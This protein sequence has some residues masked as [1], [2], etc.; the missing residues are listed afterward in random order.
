MEGL[1][2]LL[3]DPTADE[4]GVPARTF[5]PIFEALAKWG[6]VREL[7]PHLREFP[8]KDLIIFKISMWLVDQGRWGEGLELLWGPL[9]RGD[10]RHDYVTHAAAFY[11]AYVD[12]GDLADIAENDALPSVV[13]YEAMIRLS[14]SG[15]PIE[16]LA[17]SGDKDF[18]QYQ[19]YMKETRVTWEDAEFGLIRLRPAPIHIRVLRWLQ[20][21][22]G[23]V[24]N[25]LCRARRFVTNLRYARLYRLIEDAEEPTRYPRKQARAFVMHPDIDPR[26]RL[27]VSLKMLDGGDTDSAIECILGLVSDLKRET[28][29]DDKSWFDRRYWLTVAAALL[30]IIDR[31]SEVYSL[32]SLGSLDEEV[33]FDRLASMSGPVAIQ[34]CTGLAGGRDSDEEKIPVHVKRRSL[35]MLGTMK[36]SAELV[37]LVLSEECPQWIK[38]HAVRELANAGAAT[39]LLTIVSLDSQDVWTRYEAVDALGRLKRAGD[40]IALCENPAAPVA[41]RRHAIWALGELLADREEP[42]L[43]ALQE[44]EQTESL[45]PVWEDATMRIRLDDEIFAQA[46]SHAV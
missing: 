35:E 33:F 13:R 12:G 17:L 3:R 1:L 10:F 36:A 21:G 9:S 20:S 26:R 27:E 34:F 40:L 29:R 25:H 7:L 6:L 8:W 41:V 32:L 31:G 44:R 23:V 37:N 45:R 2:A 15:R 39:E 4:H 5:K 28:Q 18:K 38:V 22:A 11:C 43:R 14:E 30:V 46:S 42:E 24:I 19:D 16:S